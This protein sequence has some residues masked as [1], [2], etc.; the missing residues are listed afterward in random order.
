MKPPGRPPSPSRP[1]ESTPLVYGTSQQTSILRG[2]YTLERFWID[3]REA[4]TLIIVVLLFV[5]KGMQPFVMD[6]VH[7]T[8]AAL[9]EDPV[10]GITATALGGLVA[11]QDFSSGISKLSVA[12]VLRNLGPRNAWLIALFTGA[13]NMAIVAAVTSQASTGVIFTGTVLQSIVHAWLYPATTMTICGWVDGHWLGRAIGTVAVATKVTPIFMSLIYGAMLDSASWRSCYQFAAIGFA[14]AFVVFFLFMRSSA[15]SIG[16]R[17]PTPPGAK[18]KRKDGTDAGHS[19]APPLANEPSSCRVIYIVMCMRRTWALLLAFSLLVLLKSSAKFAS[20]YAKERLGV[21]A[22]EGT[23]LFTTY[24]VASV[25]SGLFGGVAYDIL[26]GKVGIGVLMTSLNV[27]NLCGFIYALI[28]EHM[29]IV[30]MPLL[31]VFMAIVGFSSVLPVSLP[32]Q[33]YAMAMGGVEHCGM[34]V[35]AFECFALIIESVCDLVIGGLL[36]SGQFEVWLALNIVWAASGATLMALFYYLDYRKAPK[37]NVLTSVPSMNSITR[38]Y[39]K[40][41]LWAENSLT[42]ASSCTSLASLDDEDKSSFGAGGKRLSQSSR[43]GRVRSHGELSVGFAQAPAARGMRN[44]A[45]YE[46][47]MSRAAAHPSEPPPV[48]YANASAGMG[49]PGSPGYPESRSLS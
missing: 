7:V 19:S 36:D 10:L 32:F 45:S 2:R 6:I 12:V 31:Q 30:T 46:D 33:I 40:L 1:V 47:G 44:S 42:P 28:I 23:T 49:P 21:S 20:I 13:I 15:A 11:V 48:G 16:F 17:T 38:T 41:R 34:I 37:A 25:C 5:G 26:P 14:I 18:K 9:I 24:A 3:S 39:S 35:A 8:Q 4:W 29:G 27:L 43:T 22:G